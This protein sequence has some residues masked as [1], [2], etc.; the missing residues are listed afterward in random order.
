MIYITL[1]FEFFKIGLFAIGG[2]LATLPFLYDLSGKYFWL[3]TDNVAD[4]VAISQSTPGPLGVNMAT[5]AGYQGAGLL[6]GICATIGL[7]TPSI[8]II[9]II[10]H[11][12]NKFK[13]SPYVESV[14]YGLRP[15]VTGLIAAAGYAVFEISILNLDK[16]NLTNKFL[17]IINY[18]ATLLLLGIFIVMKYFKKHPI[19]Y[20]FLGAVVG[21]VFKL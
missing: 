11:I 17:D 19:F 5:Y 15:A 6:G 9:I 4:M 12:L 21:I 1:F 18:K 3:T 2:G 20:I 16:F 7:I 10:A 13:E 14:F 8:T